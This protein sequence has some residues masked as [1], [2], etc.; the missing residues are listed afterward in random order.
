LLYEVFDIEALTQHD[1]F[2][3][4]NKNTF[5]MVLKEGLRPAKDLLHPTFEEMDQRT[6]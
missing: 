4:H 3:D 6:P 5:D 2:K 1:Y